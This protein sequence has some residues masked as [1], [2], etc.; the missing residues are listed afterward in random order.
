MSN[1]RTARMKVEVGIEPIVDKNDI[2]LSF[3]LLEPLRR[4]CATCGHEADHR[5]LGSS[6]YSIDQQ[7]F[8]RWYHLQNEL[9]QVND[10]LTQIYRP[11]NRMY[12]S[13]RNANAY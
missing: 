13:R 9:A 12:N 4:P 10:Q 11:S 1:V 8:D 2:I 7:L 3:R 5:A 6:T